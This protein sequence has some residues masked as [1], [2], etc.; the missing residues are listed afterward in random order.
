MNTTSSITFYCRKSKV[1]AAGLASIEVCVT[2]GGERMTSTLPRRC[3]PKEF[4][5]KIQSR[6]QNPIKEYTAAIATKIEELKTKCLIDGKHLTKELLRTSIQYGFAE[7]HYSVE[8]LFS[9]FLESQQKKVDAGLSTQRNH[10][11]YEIVRDLFFKHSG[12][13][14][15]T[16]ALALRQKHIIDFNT[17]LMSIYDSTTV[18]GMMQ[19][20]KSVFL[21]AL[22]N[23]MIQENP[24]MGFTI[25]RKQKDVEF[26]T[27]EE[28][29]RIRRAFMPS[30][31]L[32]RVRDLFLFQCYSAL[33]Y[34]DMAALRPSDFKTNDMGYIYINGARLKTKV[35][36]I[37]ILFEDA[38][39]IAQKYNYNLPTISNQRYNTNLKIIADICDIRKPLHTHIGRHTAAC[40]LL[41]KGL[42]L[43]IVAK[44]MGHS[45]TKLT[46]HYAK[47]LDKTVFRAVDEVMNKK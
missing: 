43:E 33:S 24:Y 19:K 38:I 18:A 1:N 8:G 30:V 28:V 17:Y 2:I 23:R 12:V 47:L 36:F 42:S 44:I 3:A 13:S 31:N 41:N 35:R 46:R 15:D 32:E 26:L 34:C 11:K 21:Y 6:T 45:T 9:T 37:A 27:E 4:R 16:N 7:H 29:D 39:T 40:Y 14:P 10:R 22:R 5:K 20:L 25:C